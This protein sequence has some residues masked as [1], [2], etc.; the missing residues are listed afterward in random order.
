MPCYMLGINIIALLQRPL[1][2]SSPE[3]TLKSR[4]GTVLAEV[5]EGHR[6]GGGTLPL[7]RLQGS[8][9]RRGELA[10]EF[11]MSADEE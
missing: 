6:P 3:V 4:L 10:E 11:G 8:R 5:S 9:W 7:L 2:A 1:N